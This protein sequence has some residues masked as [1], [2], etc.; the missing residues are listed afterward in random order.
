MVPSTINRSCAL[1]MCQSPQ[2][3]TDSKGVANVVVPLH[4]FCRHSKQ[5]AEGSLG[6]ERKA[7]LLLLQTG[8][9]FVPSLKPDVTTEPEN[10]K[11]WHS[12]ERS[13]GLSRSEKHKGF[14]PSSAGCCRCV[15]LRLLFKPPSARGM[16]M[17]EG[18]TFPCLTVAKKKKEKKKHR[19][20][21]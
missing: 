1:S 21:P 13:G 7:R 11:M 6:C 14:S 10:G 4:Y 15:R 3:S 20:S 9:P 19:H 5:L 8:F 17:A 16:Q 18:E 12:F 2:P